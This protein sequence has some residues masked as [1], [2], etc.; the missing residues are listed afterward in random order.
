MAGTSTSWPAT[1][2]RQCPK[3]SSEFEPSS[4]NTADFDLLRLPTIKELKQQTKEL[5]QK[6]ETITKSKSTEVK[7]VSADDLSQLT[8]IVEE[9]KVQR[10][11]SVH[12]LNSI[13]VLTS[14]M[15]I[16]DA[17]EDELRIEPNRE[18]V[19]EL[20]NVIEIGQN[21]QNISKVLQ[22]FK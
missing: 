2:C 10:E 6:T 13:S 20:V 1:I 15:Q 11:K 9:A 14:A 5:D 21:V 19:D 4:P 16:F 3:T 8:A 17:D 22:D 7:L 18:L 12:V